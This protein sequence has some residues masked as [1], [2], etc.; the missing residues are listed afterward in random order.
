M[1]T[2]KVALK[3]LKKLQAKNRRH[4]PKRGK[5]KKTVLKEMAEKEMVKHYVE[6]VGKFFPKL[7]SQ[8][9]KFAMKQKNWKARKEVLDRALGKSKD[10][11]EIGGE[12]GGPVELDIRIIKAMKKANE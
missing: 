2:R 6:E 4:P 5:G 12:G 10:K 1:G 9:I 11:I 8:D 3:N 7:T